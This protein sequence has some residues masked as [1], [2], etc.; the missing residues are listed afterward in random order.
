MYISA[1][2]DYALRA[3]VTLASHDGPMTADALAR[4]QGLPVGFLERILL[5]LR[6]AGLLASQ[7]GADGG[8][9]LA[10]P[11]K[12]ITPAEVMRA[13]DGPLAEVRGLRP[14]ATSYEGAAVHLQSLWV[15]VRASIR[16]VLERVTVADLATGKFPRHVQQLLDAPDAWLPR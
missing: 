15:A 12:T 7:R 2:S 8:W 1:K 3:L 5:D 11:A 16:T 10:R 13:V 14:E 4:A 6:H 9:R